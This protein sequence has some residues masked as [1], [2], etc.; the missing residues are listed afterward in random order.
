MN[1]KSEKNLSKFQ[2]IK[3]AFNMGE[4]KLRMEFQYNDERE[5]TT[6]RKV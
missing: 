4:P 2:K 1:G 6:P 5:F 3:A